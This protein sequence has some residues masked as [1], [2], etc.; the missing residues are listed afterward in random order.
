M[1]N[2]SDGL[3]SSYD[4]DFDEDEIRKAKAEK[5]RKKHNKIGSYLI[6]EPA[7]F[8][9]FYAFNVSGEC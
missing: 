3:I 5:Y 6:L 9:L 1:D 7:A 2:E 4:N 8:L